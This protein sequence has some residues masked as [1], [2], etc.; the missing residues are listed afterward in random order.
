VPY[1]YDIQSR[2]SKAS[3]PAVRRAGGQTPETAMAKDEA[4]LLKAAI[5]AL[6]DR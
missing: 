1:P 6:P 5:A 4:A 3:R 2:T